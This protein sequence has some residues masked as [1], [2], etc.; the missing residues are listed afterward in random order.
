[1]SVAKP[2]YPLGTG[3]VVAIDAAHNN[4][5]T[6]DGRYRPLAGLLENDGYRVRSN[7]VPFTRAT[8]DSIEVLVIANAIAI[9][10]E[11]AALA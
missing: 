11:C 5:H 3:S 4:F 2:T 8:L 7:E 9:R 1:V 6:K 10:A